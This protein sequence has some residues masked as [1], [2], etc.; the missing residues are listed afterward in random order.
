LFLLLAVAGELFPPFGGLGV[1][2]LAWFGG[3]PGVVEVGQ[4]LDAL[5]GSFVILAE[6]VGKQ[7]MGFEQR[8]LGGRVRSHAA[9]AGPSLDK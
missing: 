9:W 1:V 2:A 8:A 6:A 7:S 3:V 5:A 4:A